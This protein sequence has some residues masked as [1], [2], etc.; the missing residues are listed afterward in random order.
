MGN[1]EIVK[2]KACGN[3]SFIRDYGRA[4]I[5]AYTIDG[6]SPVNTE[7]YFKCAKCYCQL[8]L[9]E[10]VTAIGDVTTF[11]FYPKKKEVV[12]STNK[13]RT[14]QE[15]RESVFDIVRDPELSRGYKEDVVAV[16]NWVL[17]GEPFDGL[18][19]GK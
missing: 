13:M 6:Q 9:K 12:E 18:A 3:E 2:C 7:M 4:P 19:Q 17:G 5:R 11:Y 15:I 14:E 16:L 8:D 1:Q 10:P